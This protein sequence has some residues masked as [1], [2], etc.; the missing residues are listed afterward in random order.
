M[1]RTIRIRVHLK[2]TMN[3]MT[4]NI[5]A[6]KARQG[7]RGRHVL[8]ILIVSLAL[9]GVVWGLVE[10]YGRSIEPASPSTQTL[11]N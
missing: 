4:K 3:P 1:E 6:T 5:P 7:L 11:Q 8:T 9:V 2:R 10:Y